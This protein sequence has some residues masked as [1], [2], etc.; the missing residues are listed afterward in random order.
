MRSKNYFFNS[1]L[2]GTLINNLK[3]KKYILLFILLLI[4]LVIIFVVN[5]NYIFKIIEGNS[6]NNGYCK[7]SGNKSKDLEK[8]TDKMAKEYKNNK[9]K[10]KSDEVDKSKTVLQNTGTASRGADLDIPDE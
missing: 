7:F 1:K 8:N 9:S 6:S 5:Y 2:L 3:S 4:L 10:N